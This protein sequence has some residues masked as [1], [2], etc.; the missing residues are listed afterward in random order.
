MNEPILL[1]SGGIDSYITWHYMNKPQVLFVDYGQPYINIEKKAVN[2]LY[3]L[4]VK[5]V[6]IS[7]LK[8]LNDIYVPARNLMMA[9]LAL[10][11]STNIVFGAVK[12]EMCRDKSPRAFRIMAKTLSEFNKRDVLVYS[13]IWHFTKSEAVKW[14]INSGHN[15]QDLESTVSCYSDNLCNNCESC[16]RRFVA[17][18]VNGVIQADRIP[19][20]DIIKKFMKSLHAQPCNRDKEIALALLNANIVKKEDIHDDHIAYNGIIGRFKK[21]KYE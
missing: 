17:L 8:E 18:A 7:G 1:V 15:I 11:F 16:F 2:K 3:G 9:S 10:R 6:T 12:D 21:K 4:N 5:E 13:P 20:H 14:Y 19:Q